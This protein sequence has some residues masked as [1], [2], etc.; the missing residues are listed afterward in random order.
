MTGTDILSQLKEKTLGD[1]LLLPGRH[2]F[3][4]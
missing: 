1:E 4:A 2:A 3:A